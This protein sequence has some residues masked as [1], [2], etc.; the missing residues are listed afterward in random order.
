MR[1]YLPFLL[2]SLFCLSVLAPDVNR[3]SAQFVHLR[4]L[5]TVPNCASRSHLHLL[6]QSHIELSCLDELSSTLKLHNLAWPLH[7]S[8]ATYSAHNRLMVEVQAYTVRFK[9]TTPKSPCLDG[10]SL[11]IPPYDLMC[12][13]HMLPLS[14]WALH[15]D[16]ELTMRVLF[17]LQFNCLNVFSRLRPGINCGPQYLDPPPFVR[18]WCLR[19]PSAFFLACSFCQIFTGCLSMPSA[20]PCMSVLPCAVPC[21]PALPCAVPRWSVLSSVVSCTVQSYCKN[22]IPCILLFD[23]VS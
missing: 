15:A 23:T 19:Q 6:E 2:S 12:L 1:I 11:T 21:L 18:V 13:L 7:V 14:P 10:P 8:L 3:S 9:S 5:F 16:N 22:T 20:I 17:F 4:S